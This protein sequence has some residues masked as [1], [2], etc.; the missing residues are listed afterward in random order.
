MNFD[1]ILNSPSSTSS[2]CHPV[3]FN[4]LP[5][6]F[7]TLLTT[8]TNPAAPGIWYQNMSSATGTSQTTPPRPH[9]PPP[10]HTPLNLELLTY[11]YIPWSRRT[12]WPFPNPPPSYPGRRR[13]EMPGGRLQGWEPFI[14]LWMGFAVV[15][16][17]VFVAVI[18]WVIG[19]V[20]RG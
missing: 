11:T 18:S 12:N 15:I 19:E 9:S 16:V 20:G 17:G 1:S 10:S 6:F 7:I 14:P 2:S 4:S 8:S 3:Q 13:R 5:S